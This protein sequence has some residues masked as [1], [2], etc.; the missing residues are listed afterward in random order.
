MSAG[1][2]FP[3]RDRNSASAGLELMPDLPLVLR[4]QSRSVSLVG[5]V[6]SGAM[7]SVLPFSLGIQLGLDWNTQNVPIALHGS[8]SDV[9]ACGV[10]VEAVV[11]RL[12]PVRLTFAWTRSDQVPCLLGQFNFFHVFDVCFFRARKVFEVR[13]SGT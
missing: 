6:D 10:V 1:Q 11:G 3:Y 7:I 12:P 8:L 9:G 2:Q 13:Q 4:H 5:L